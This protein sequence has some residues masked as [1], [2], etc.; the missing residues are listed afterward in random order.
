MRGRKEEHECPSGRSARTQQSPDPVLQVR[1]HG[2]AGD[3]SRRRG[4]AVEGRGVSYESG[5]EAEWGV[6]ASDGAWDAM[7]KMCIYVDFWV[8]EGEL[9]R[10]VCRR[11]ILTIDTVWL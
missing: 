5:Y 11:V 3:G 6:F 1:R 4:R 7:K 10:G 9:D 8:L 2:R